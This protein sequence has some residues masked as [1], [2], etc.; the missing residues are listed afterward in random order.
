[1]QNLMQIRCSTISVI[2]NA[3]AT[4]YTHSLNGIYCPCWLVQWSYHCLHIHIPVHSPWLPDYIDVVQTILVILTIAGLFL[5]RPLMCKR[6]N[7]LFDKGPWQMAPSISYHSHLRWPLTALNQFALEINFMHGYN[8]SAFRG[9]SQRD[10]R[11]W[12]LWG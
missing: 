12:Q 8:Q 10:E 1:M 3:T 11:S 6:F 4:Q 7:T 2:L 5:D 9:R